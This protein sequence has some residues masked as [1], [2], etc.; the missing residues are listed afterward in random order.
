MN[1]FTIHRYEYSI[2]QLRI[3][4]LLLVCSPTESSYCD[5]YEPHGKAN[6]R[7][8]LLYI[9]VPPQSSLPNSQR[10][11]E[12]YRNGNDH[13]CFS[14]VILFKGGGF[15]ESH[16][17]SWKAGIE[18]CESLFGWECNGIFTAPVGKGY[19]SLLWLERFVL[20]NTVRFIDVLV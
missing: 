16:R 14:L 9:Q 19:A 20:P 10:S 2:F 1:A 15:S 5:C 11:S 6:Q 17:H 7:S 12:D 4:T 3:Y 13:I 18:P 8:F